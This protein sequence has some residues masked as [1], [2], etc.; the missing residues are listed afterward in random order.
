MCRLSHLAC[1]GHRFSWLQT[2]F[3]TCSDACWAAFLSSGQSQEPEESKLAGYDPHGPRF[4]LLCQECLEL[5]RRQRQQEGLVYARKHFPAFS[6]EHF[7]ELRRAMAAMA[8]GADTTCSRYAELFDPA[9]WDLL[10]ELFQKDLFQMNF[11]TSRSML[12]LHLQVGSCCSC[13]CSCRNLWLLTA[14]RC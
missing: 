6:K 13:C 11:L 4:S 7:P 3:S 2:A 12:D 8:F 10:I 1:A 5:V 14:A 9:R